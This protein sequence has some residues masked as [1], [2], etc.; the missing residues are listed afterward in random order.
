MSEPPDLKE[1]E[2]CAK[3]EYKYDFD[4]A[5]LMIALLRASGYTA[6]YVYGIIRVNPVGSA[7]SFPEAIMCLRYCRNVAQAL[8]NGGW[9]PSL[10]A[11]N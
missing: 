5:S 1:L 8:P 6:N 2:S 9:N 10:P 3:S 4:Q 11:P 7:C